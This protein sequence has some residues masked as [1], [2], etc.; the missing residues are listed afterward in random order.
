MKK[1]LLIAI[2]LAILFLSSCAQ[3]I[4]KKEIV[5]PSP[6]NNTTRWIILAQFIKDH[7]NTPTPVGEIA[8]ELIYQEYLLET[9]ER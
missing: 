6:A 9:K 2:L 8:A 3:T 5:V 1:I 7:T 4:S